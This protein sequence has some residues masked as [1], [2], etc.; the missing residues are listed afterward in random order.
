MT[1]TEEHPISIRAHAVLFDLDGTLVD[2]TNA[3]VAHWTRFGHENGIP[4]ERILATSHGRRLIDT[5]LEHTPHLASDTIANELE[6]N[7]PKEFGDRCQ[8]ILGAPEI[9]Q[10]LDKVFPDDRRWGIV[11]SGTSSLASQWLDM[12]GMPI[13]DVFITAEKVGRG[14]PDPEGYV[15]G[16]RLLGADQSLGKKAIVFEDAPAGIRAG[17]AAGAVV[18]GIASTHSKAEVLDAGA[19]FVVTDLSQI[20]VVREPADSDDF[21]IR[22]LRQA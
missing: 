20:E 11:T 9:V 3:I 21:V 15:L 17:K 1:V 4:P 10:R 16:R 12:F 6:S 19:D 7:L 18:I 8:S 2:S 22:I 5:L 13:P 14:K